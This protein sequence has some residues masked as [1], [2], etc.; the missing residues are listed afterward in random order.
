MGFPATGPSHNLKKQGCVCCSLKPPE[1]REFGTAPFSRLEIPIKK[2]REP[3][4][5]S[6]KSFSLNKEHS[7]DTSQTFDDRVFK[8]ASKCVIDRNSGRIIVRYSKES[9]KKISY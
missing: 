5:Y 9:V 3:N 2:I 8:T 7:R 6:R 4:D 1:L